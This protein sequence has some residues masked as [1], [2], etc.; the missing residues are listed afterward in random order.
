[1]TAKVPIIIQDPWLSHGKLLLSCISGFKLITDIFLNSLY[2]EV[3]SKKKQQG[4][5]DDPVQ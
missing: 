2:I 1:M 4:G 3:L 5:G